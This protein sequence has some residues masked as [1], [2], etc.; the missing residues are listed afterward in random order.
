MNFKS[1]ALSALALAAASAAN[2]QSTSSVTIYGVM[3]AGVQYLDGANSLYRVQS[4]GQSG[5]RIGFRGNED[6]GGGLRAQ[7]QIESGIN[8]DDG[9]QGQG[10]MWGRQA[11]VGLT[12]NQFGSVSLGRQYSSL[13]TLSNDFSSF[14]NLGGGAS[15]AV[16]GG[17]GPNGAFEP[18]RGST[19]SGTGNGGPARVNNSLKYESPSFS[20][21][22]VGG[23]WGMGEA[24]TGAKNTRVTDV[25]GRY[26]ASGL[27]VAIAYTQDKALALGQNIAVITAAASYKFGDFKVNGGWMDVNDK[28]ATN[29]DGHGAWIGGDWKVSGP[30]TVRAQYVL[31]KADYGSKGKTNAFGVGYQYDLSKRTDFYAMATRFN[32]SGTGYTNRYN[33]AIPAG[34]TDASHRNITELMAGVRHSF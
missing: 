2:A 30:H 4:G 13:Y 22:K 27:D 7:F 23:L 24:S 12:S 14:A 25:Y 3:D 33:S 6:L 28:G 9:S 10:A 19:A 20:G 26:T 18:V 17:F 16:I 31:N 15:T 1:F 21:F 5:S 8:L 29:Q 34:V 11:W 32:N